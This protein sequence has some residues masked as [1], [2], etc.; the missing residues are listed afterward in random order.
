M[1]VGVAVTVVVDV[2]VVK[3]PGDDRDV[4]NMR[5]RRCRSR[6]GRGRR[7]RGRRRSTWIAMFVQSP[8]SKVQSM[9]RDVSFG[10]KQAMNYLLVDAQIFQ[11]D[12]MLLILYQMMN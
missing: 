1:V 11:W 7:G 4:S 6:C 10:K 12:V 5:G 3:V 8:K 2:A 9:D